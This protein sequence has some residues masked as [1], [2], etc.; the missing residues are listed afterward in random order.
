MKYK[1]LLSH[2]ENTRKVE[3]EEKTKFL[4]YILEETG[5][6]IQDFWTS[7]G[8]LSIAQRMQLREIL[9]NYDIQVIDSLDGLLQIYMNNEIVAEFFK[10]K[11]TLK[12]DLRQVDPRKRPYMEMEVSFWSLFEEAENNE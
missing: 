7:D 9:S 6:P 5:L 10:P 3:D 12:M 1:L 8:S 11:Y 4:K 2:N